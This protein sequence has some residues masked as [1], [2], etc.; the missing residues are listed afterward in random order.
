MAMAGLLTRGQPAAVEAIKRAI[1]DERPPS[2]LLIAGPARVGK[3]TLALDLAAGLLC[4]ALSAFVPTAHFGVFAGAATLVALPG[5]L[6][7][8]PAF[9][10]LLRAL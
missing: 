3:T 4:L 5:D 8:F 1:V 9:A 10:R 6:I 2:A 7:V